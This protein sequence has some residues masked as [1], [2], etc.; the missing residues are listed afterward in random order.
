MRTSVG[1]HNEGE[2]VGRRERKVSAD[3]RHHSAQSAVEGEAI[4]T[5]RP[6]RSGRI[7]QDPEQSTAHECRQSY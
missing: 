7:Q 2:F 1:R 5:I 3:Q 6:A 4:G